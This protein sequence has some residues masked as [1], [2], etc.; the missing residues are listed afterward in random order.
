MNKV[1]RFITFTLIILIATVIFDVNISNAATT[2]TVSI[3]SAI[4]STIEDK[5]YTGKEI[6]PDI[7]ISYK[8][9]TLAKGLDYNLTYSNNI[10]AGTGKITII[11]MG[12]YTG[13]KTKT[14][15]IA[16]KNVDKLSINVD[17]TQKYSGTSLKP[18][19]TVK[20]GN[21]LLTKSVDYTVSYSNNTKAGAGIVKVTGKGNYTGTIEKTF[22]IESLPISGATFSKISNQEYTGSE[23]LPKVTVKVNNRT[24][25]L[26]KDYTVSGSNNI[27][28]GTATLKITGIGNYTGTASTTFNIVSRNL[29]K[30]KFS[31][32]EDYDY[33]AKNIH[34]TVEAF[35]GDTKLTEGTDYK[36]S[37]GN[38]KNVGTGKIQIIGKGNYKGTK[39]LTF[40]ITKIDICEAVVSPIPTQYYTGS[41]IK[42]RIIVTHNGR[43]LIQ[44]EDYKVSFSNNKQVGTA[45]VKITGMGNFT[46]YFTT[47]FQ[48]R[49]ESSNYYN[50]NYYYDNYN[51]NNKY[52]YDDYYYDNYNYNNNYN[53]NDNYYYDNYNYN[54]D[55][56]NSNKK[57]S[58][59]KTTVSTIPDQEYTGSNITPTVYVRY[60]GQLLTRNQDY[61]LS[62]SNNK[63]VG[64]ASI[65]I[66]GK[67]NFTG[68]KTV[69]FK[70]VR[71]SSS[72]NNNTKGS[73]SI[74]KTTVSAIP[75]QEYT[76]SNITPTVYVRYNGQLLTRN[77]DY[78]LSYSNNKNVGTASIKITG[79]N[80][81]TGS[82]TVKFKIV[83]SSNSY[84]NNTNNKG[85]ISII[86]TTASAIINQQYTGRAITPTI[87]LRYNGTL[88]T[89]GK[90][91]T[92]TYSNNINV[93]TAK[94][95]ITGIGN[96]YGTKTLSFKIVNNTNSN[97]NYNN[98][99]YNT[100]SISISKTTASTIYNQQYTGRAITPTVYL[101]YNGTLLTQG[102]DYTV[103]Y[104]NNVNVGTAKVTITGIGNYYGTKTLSFR[105]VR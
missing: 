1:K 49:R 47:S 85:K 42:P 12:N 62:Y 7:T 25:S 37:F 23:I 71:S 92:A 69:K 79:K 60:N 20:D 95:T 43:Q 56:Y 26:N 73:I 70:I 33:T 45:T 52:Y 96:Y 88:L 39:N 86:K 48:I 14:F 30:V 93:G 75:D 84:N 9:I 61:T 22:G 101:R 76:G 51:Y 19:V 97:Y 66:T 34:P 81:F 89:Q 21:T 31:K 38:N 10:K 72:Y 6:T 11:G 4:V 59:T 46:S 57:I 44:N 18:D 67:N 2:T 102:R 58:I 68:S 41:A 105:I 24:L 82:K 65:K 28:V 27:N 77:Q 90:D 53:Y 36:I 8:G 91:Y 83:R 3:T 50:D 35:N 78:T 63:N 100:G 5:I 74:T 16:K 17:S 15:K 40:R 98:N 87:Y 64:T 55:Y 103:T 29:S 32:I 99:N 54:N 13:T 104:S 80:N 94:V